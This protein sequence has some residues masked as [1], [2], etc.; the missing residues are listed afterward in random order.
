MSKQKVRGTILI[1]TTDLPD[2]E[3][4]KDLKRV[5]VCQ[6]VLRI[7]NTLLREWNLVWSKVSTNLASSGMFLLSTQLLSGCLVLSSDAWL[8]WLQSWTGMVFLCIVEWA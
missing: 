7:P 4:N 2:G 3:E 1:R 8:E 5:H 6:P